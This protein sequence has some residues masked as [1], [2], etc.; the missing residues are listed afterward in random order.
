VNIKKVPRHM[1]EYTSNNGAVTNLK[2]PAQTYFTN[3]IVKTTLISA[4]KT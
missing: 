2:I 3:N 1:P 4:F